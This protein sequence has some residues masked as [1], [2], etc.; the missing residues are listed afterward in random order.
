MRPASR[1]ASSIIRC[2][3][4]SD[5]AWRIPNRSRIPSPPGKEQE[6]EDRLPLHASLGK[7]TARV[8]LSRGSAH[9]EIH[10]TSFDTPV[11]LL[12]YGSL[13]TR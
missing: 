13:I 9:W 5:G 2:P 6:C 12:M 8:H 7:L 4:R 10:A 1:K 3:V 11:R